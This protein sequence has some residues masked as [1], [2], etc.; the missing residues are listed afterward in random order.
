[1]ELQLADVTLSYS[2]VAPENP[3]AVLIIVHGLSEHGGRYFKLQLEL[4]EVDFAVF[5]YDQRGF[6]KS[7][8]RRTD[9]AHYTDFLDDLK[10]MIVVARNTH[11]KIP[12]FLIGHSLGGLVVSAFCIH[13]PN[14]VDGIILSAPAYEFFP[15]P[16]IIHFMGVVLNF[17]CPTIHIRY[18]S[19]P[20]KLSHDPEMT[21]A[22]R[23]DPL[24]QSSG[25]P[26]FY[27]A[28]RKMND[29]VKRRADQIALPVLILQGTGDTIVV[30]EGAQRLYDKIKSEK[31][32]L[33]F[34]DRFYH[35]P[36]NEMGRER[37]VA[38]LFSWLNDLLQNKGDKICQ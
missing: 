34:Y 29:M 31:K 21:T 14:G 35:E 38:D 19:N 6:G 2:L 23:A 10:A 11:P 27:Y 3:R 1:M 4:A 24:I 36:F 26:R 32:R 16:W 20:E 9:V 13:F 7:T 33:I 25:T 18:P 5:A 28:L 37:V 8:G 12:L 30:P 22:F 15:L 17:V